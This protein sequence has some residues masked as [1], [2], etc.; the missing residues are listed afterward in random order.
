MLIQI[1]MAQSAVDICPDHLR[2]EVESTIV[3]FDRVYRLT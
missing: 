1:C 2:F 3:V